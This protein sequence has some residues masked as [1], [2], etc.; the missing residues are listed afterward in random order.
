[1]AIQSFISRPSPRMPIYFLIIITTIVFEGHL[2][3]YMS[4]GESRSKCSWPTSGGNVLFVFKSF[5]SSY[6][7]LRR[8]Q[9]E[10]FGRYEQ[11]WPSFSVDQGSQPALS[12]WQA[13]HLKSLF[14]RIIRTM[15]S[16]TPQSTMWS[17]NPS[18]SIQMHFIQAI[19]SEPH[20]L[21]S[22]NIMFLGIFVDV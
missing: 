18:S 13:L 1:M 7:R 10:R 15:W 21:S 5:F 16:S 6:L 11:S 20:M 2:W 4:W 22:L 19:T 9:S 3:L 14:Q 8:G 17:S 12:L